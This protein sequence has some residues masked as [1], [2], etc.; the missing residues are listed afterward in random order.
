MAAQ[1]KD[2]AKVKPIYF[3]YG[4][5]EYLVE[6]AVDRI[7]ARVL[8]GGFDS[9]NYHVFNAA[10]TQRS[11]SVEEV[12]EVAMTL[13]AFAEKRFV[14]VKNAE[15]LRAEENK[16]FY[17]YARDPSP[18]TCLVFVSNTWKVNKQSKLFKELSSRGQVKQFYRLKEDALVRWAVEYVKGEGK[19]MAAPVAAKLIAITGSR[20]MDV[21]SECDKL[22][23][24]VGD[25]K[26]I[27]GDDVAVSVMDLKE[28]TAFD[29][30]DALARR[31]SSTAFSVLRKLEG[32]EPLK[33]LGA[34]AW[35][36]RVI[37]KL[38]ALVDKNVPR[39]KMAGMVRVS[40]SR[41]S[42][43]IK[44][45]GHFTVSELRGVLHKFRRV[46]IDIKS[47]RFPKRLII[48]RL[49]MDICLSR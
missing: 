20:V 12:V 9:L 28:E 43:Y 10:Q 45:S 40:P 35:Q 15:A 26:V 19:T 3:F 2:K 23:G 25:R 13:P 11:G 21:K 6:D 33:V 31:D 49:V 14:L 30:A 42:Q 37:I 27:E 29:L 48:D 34:I 7:K 1:S 46:D 38:R 36:F 39:Q 5:E 17:E 4:D 41:L 22:L 44:A 32:E 47:G 18:T 16:V 24:Y 8:G